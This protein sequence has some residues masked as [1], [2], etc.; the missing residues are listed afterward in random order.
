MLLLERKLIWHLLKC[1]ITL[2]ETIDGDTIKACV[3]GKV[4]RI[5]YLLIDTP[6]RE[7]R[8]CESIRLQRKIYIGIT[9]W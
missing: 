3:Y 7:S 8:G 5:R 9:S 6:E 1:P 2:V 4:E